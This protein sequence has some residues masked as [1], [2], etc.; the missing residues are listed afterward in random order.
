VYSASFRSISAFALALALGFSL[1]SFMDS[2]IAFRET[3][4][5]LSGWLLLLGFLIFKASTS[6]Y[7]VP[8]KM[9]ERKQAALRRESCAGQLYV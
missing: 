7:R 4:Y 2:R 8:V 3:T 5:H 1:A 6:S 9:T